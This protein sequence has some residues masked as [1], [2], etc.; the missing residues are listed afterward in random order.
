MWQWTCFKKNFSWVF[1]LRIQKFMTWPIVFPSIFCSHK[2][3]RRHVFSLKNTFRFHQPL[4]TEGKCY[5]LNVVPGS[6][7]SQPHAVE[8]GDAETTLGK[9]I[10]FQQLFLG[11]A[12][13]GLV[14]S[15]ALPLMRAY[16]PSKS[17]LPL[18]LSCLTLTWLK[19]RK[20]RDVS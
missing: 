2:A 1:S 17:W 9:S 5:C 15:A 20:S 18:N 10:G 7:A 6:W 16:L 12:I 19:K 8:D 4:S 3:P 14:G 11:W 13:P